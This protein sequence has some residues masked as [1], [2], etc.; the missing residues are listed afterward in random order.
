MY[1]L[2]TQDRAEE[3]LVLEA[4]KVRSVVATVTRLEERRHMFVADTGYLGSCREIDS[5]R[6]KPIRCGVEEAAE[7]LVVQ[8]WNLMDG[9]H[10]L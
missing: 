9:S 8:I 4:N 7:R 2:L 1:S 3:A 5:G 6:R 10:N